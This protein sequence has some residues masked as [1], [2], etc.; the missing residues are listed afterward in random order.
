MPRRRDAGRSLAKGAIPVDQA[1]KYAIEIATALDAAHRH[2]IVHRDLKPGN[3][4]LTKTGVKL[5]DFGLA[6]LKTAAQGPLGD[7]TMV[8]GTGVARCSAR[9]R[10]WRRSRSKGVT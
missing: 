7:T 3:I 10:I 1:I 2:G 9:C 6:K 8:K 4:M 5:L